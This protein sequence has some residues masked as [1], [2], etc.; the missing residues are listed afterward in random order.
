M[1]VYWPW[2]L[3]SIVLAGLTLVFWLSFHRTLGVS[4]SWARV[5]M[6]REDRLINQAE[7]PFRNNPEMLKDALMAATINEF[8]AKAV[9]QALATH[10]HRHD[11]APSAPVTET[12]KKL[13]R[14]ASSTAHLVFLVMLVTGGFLSSVTTGGFTPQFDLGEVHTK[15]FGTGLGNWIILILGGALVGFGTQMAG[16]CTSGHGLSGCSRLVPASLIATVAFFGTA[17]GVSFLI[18][19]FGGVPS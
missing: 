8:G 13:P 4:G 11:A 16:G 5:V 3:G 14:R 12:P 10:K 1:F 6:W 2:W 17:V 19:F 7:A 18:H 15:V 9:A